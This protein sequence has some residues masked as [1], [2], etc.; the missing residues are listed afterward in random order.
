MAM[1]RPGFFEDTSLQNPAFCGPLHM[2]RGLAC[3]DLDNDGDVDLLVTVIDGPARLY[4]NRSAN[5]TGAPHWLWVRLILP[6]RGGRD[7][8]G[9]EMVVYGGGKEWRRQLQPAFSYLCS[10]EPAA[11]V[12]LGDLERFDRIEV[13]WPDGA[14]EGFPGGAANR[15]LILRRGDGQS[16]E[17]EARSSADQGR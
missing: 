1:T 8:I 14:A 9:A 3:G 2:G 12:G 4:R 10:N 15:R 16:I 13:R 5:G 7:A 6:E 17:T 11:H